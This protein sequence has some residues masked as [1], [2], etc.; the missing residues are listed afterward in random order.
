[1]KT[2]KFHLL[3]GILFLSTCLFSCSDDDD[4]S[5]YSIKVN[6]EIWKLPEDISSIME[7]NSGEWH[8]GFTMTFSDE[9]G[10]EFD[11]NKNINFIFT[12]S[13]PQKGDDVAKN[14][15]YAYHYPQLS[16]QLTYNYKSGTAI[17]TDWGKEY[18]TI[19]LTDLAMVCSN[20]KNGASSEMVFNGTLKCEV[21]N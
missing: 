10:V 4:S 13:N 15:L 16:T 21:Y 6:N 11:V 7:L 18:V 17:I 3:V 1:M 19:K 20:P 8:F 12:S 9:E 5:D 14:N 2:K